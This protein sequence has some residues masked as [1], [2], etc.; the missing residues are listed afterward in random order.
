MEHF[1]RPSE[2][3]GYLANHI[4]LLR[5]SFRHWTGR[6]LVNPRLIDRNAARYVFSGPFVLVSH[7]NSHDP[8]FNY[9]NETA[10]GLFGMSW[11]EF[12]RLPSRLSAQPVSQEE[13]ARLLAEVTTQGFID[14][15]QGVRIA[16]GG[17]RFR[18]E[19][20]TVWNVVDPA[21][22]YHGQAA[23]FRH[24]TF[25]GNDGETAPEGRT[26]AGQRSLA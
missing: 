3:N 12:T 8:I 24:W 6:D 1:S 14:H 25:L 5:Y 16:H 21:G 19:Q 2:D 23:T 26:P 11:E 7:D 17:R 20:A 22:V 10:L 9:A 4:A 13:R 18:I 15:Y